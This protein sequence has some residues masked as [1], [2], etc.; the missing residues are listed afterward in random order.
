MAK[1]GGKHASEGERSL[2][3]WRTSLGGREVIGQ[4]LIVM[5]VG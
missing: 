3:A 2:V 5:M 1:L 4:A